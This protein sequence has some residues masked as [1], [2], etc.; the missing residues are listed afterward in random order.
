MSYDITYMW[1]LIKMIQMN[2]QNRNRALLWLSQLGI[3]CCHCCGPRSLLWHEFNPG[4]GTS[5][6]HSCDQKTQPKPKLNRHRLTDLEIKLMV[7]KG[8]TLGEGINQEFGINIYTLPYV[9]KDL[10]YSTGASTQYSVINYMG[11]EPEKEQIYVHVKLNCFAI[12]ETN[13]I[14]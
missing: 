13:T 5:A 4:P 1:N 10:L 11:K 2:L 12:H 3:W 6:C 9:K 14:L 7:T 8:E